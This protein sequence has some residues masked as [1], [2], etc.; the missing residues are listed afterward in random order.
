MKFSLS[1][2][3][4]FREYLGKLQRGNSSGGTPK[5]VIRLS[6][7]SPVHVDNKVGYKH[8]LIFIFM[9]YIKMCKR[10]STLEIDFLL[11]CEYLE[12]RISFKDK[13][14]QICIV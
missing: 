7:L 13:A 9:S 8:H 1:V 12:I 4:S 10:V 3:L 6:E 11:A 14:Y 5:N 2:L